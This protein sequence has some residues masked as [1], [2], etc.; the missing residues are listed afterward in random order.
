MMHDRFVARWAEWLGRSIKLIGARKAA[1]LIEERL[2][3]TE[4]A[5]VRSRYL[6]DG[7][8]EITN[9]LATE[10]RRTPRT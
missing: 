7:M 8:K 10:A 5:R 6:S 3:E 1:I 4:V 9:G 2:P